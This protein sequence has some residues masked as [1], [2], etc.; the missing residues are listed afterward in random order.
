MPKCQLRELF[1]LKV[2]NTKSMQ[3]K[4]LKKEDAHF[5]STS[6]SCRTPNPVISLPK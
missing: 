2:L 3:E 6:M 4:N 5:G 1:D